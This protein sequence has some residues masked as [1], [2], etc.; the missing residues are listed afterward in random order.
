MPFVAHRVFGWVPVEID[1]SWGLRTIPNGHAYSI[2][3][4]LCCEECGMLFL[5]IRFTDTEMEAL[6]R[7]YR[8][9]EYTALREHYEPGYRARNDALNA[10]DA[11]IPHVEAFLSPFLANRL[12]VLDWGGDT[13]INTPFRDRAELFHVHDISAKAV[14]AGA[15][16]VD[17]ETARLI[18]YDLIVCSNVLEHIPWPL[19]LLAQITACMGDATILYIEVPHEELVRLHGGQ[20]DLCTRKRHWHEHINFF[21]RKSLMRMLEVAGLEILRLE[22]LADD[23]DHIMPCQLMVAC[24]LSAVDSKS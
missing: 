12:R 7:G 24:R 11:H 23:V 3:N 16:S 20:G 22:E 10:G 19:D 17:L 4:S 15:T 5:D 13:G 8:Q 18:G 14:V 2:C 6:Y 1:D 21:G 9:E